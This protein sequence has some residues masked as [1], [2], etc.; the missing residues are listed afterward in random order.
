MGVRTSVVRA[1]ALTALALSVASCDRWPWQKGD[2]SEGAITD[3]AAKAGFADASFHHA[4]E[5]YFREMDGGVALDPT[6]EAGR[7]MWLVWTGGNDKFWDY[8]RIPT[9]SGFD[10]L[11]V[12]ASPPDELLG[13]R[14]RWQW[15]GA[16]NEPCFKAPTKPDRFGIWVDERDPGCP[17]DPFADEKRYPGIKTGARGKNLPKWGV[18]PVGSIYGYPTG[19]VGLRLFP[20]PDFNEAA[21]AAWDPVRYYKDPAYYNDPKLVRPYRVGMSCGFCHVGPSPTN[22][23]DDPA[24]PKWENL[25]STVGAQYLWADRFFIWNQKDTDFVSQWVRTFRPG[26][27]DTSLVSSDNINNPRTMNALYNVEAR[28]KRGGIT[29]EEVLAGGGVNNKQFNHYIKDGWLTQFY[30]SGSNHVKVPRILKDGSDSVGALGA[31][32]RVFLNIGLFSEDWITHFRPVTGGKPVTPI[33]LSLAQKNSAYWRATEAGTPA[34]ALFFLKAARPDYLAAAPG[35]AALADPPALVAQGRRVFSDTCARCHSSKGPKPPANASLVEVDG[36]GYLEKFKRWWRWTQSEDFKTQMW[37]DYV[38]KPDFLQGNYMSTEARIPVT[39]LRTNLCSPLATNAI[40]GNIWD[41]FSSQTYKRLP[42]VGQASFRDPFTGQALPYAMP[43]GGR[44]YTRPPSLISLWSTAPFLLNNTV[45]PFY[46]DP[47]V[48]AR[49]R[50]FNAAIQQM[51]WPE[52]RPFDAE[53]G[54]AS[55]GWIDR[56]TAR[57]SIV[58]PVG[59]FK[60]LPGLLGKEEQDLLNRLKDK[61]DNIRIGSI[62]KGMPVNLLVN[63]RPLPE[64]RDVGQIR[65]HYRNVFK[66]LL[67]LK[68]D[69][70]TMPANATDPQL[71][72]HFANLRGPLM[73]LSKCPDFVVNRGHYFGTKQFNDPRG[74][75]P[76]ELFFLGRPGVPGQSEPELNDGQKRAL[77]AFLK[78]L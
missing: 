28:L 72:Q 73:G 78:T 74:L 7:N 35:G 43:A 68:R 71:R 49:M 75:T 64:S 58:I 9:N 23:P 53:I 44:G 40:G 22:P 1:I 17:P 55:G 37:R 51:L 4:A 45:G 19:I 24:N 63:L 15:L 3:E 62:P 52:R 46:Q 12:A 13:R 60:Q 8:M 42:S 16:I 77:I 18:L 70:A 56:T 33:Q 47:S 21:A 76:D 2:D 14:K 30:D 50:S 38:S 11:K 36:P 32:N 5:P 65:A 69:L 66:A 20:N 27:L 41:N 61:D 31:L 10:L 34:I 29:G 57:S 48:A 39:L 54:P 67:A 59:F 26:A 6:E 25:S